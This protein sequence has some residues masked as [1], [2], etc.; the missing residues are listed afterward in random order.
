[1]DSTEKRRPFGERVRRLFHRK[2]L[3]RLILTSMTLFL[4]PC[5]ITMSV[6][7][8][9]SYNEVQRANENSALALTDAFSERFVDRLVLLQNEAYQFAESSRDSQSALF[10][11]QIPSLEQSPY[12]YYT[13]MNALDQYSGTNFGLYYAEDD[14]LI[15]RRGK[16]G[17]YG[18]ARYYL[19]LKSD[20]L[21]NRMRAFM[22]N[23]S[24]KTLSF[25]PL[26]DENTCMVYAA[27]RVRL[28][29]TRESVLLFARLDEL[30]SADMQPSA[31]HYAVLDAETN[32][33]IYTTSPDYFIDFSDF[34]AEKTVQSL[35]RSGTV[36][37][38]FQSAYD[39]LGYRYVGVM[40]QESL[41]SSLKQFYDMARRV[42]LLFCI[43]LLIAMALLI[44]VTYHPIYRL[45]KSLSGSAE[46]S[47]LEV[48]S[49]SFEQI[50]DEKS[51][52][53]MMVIDLLL[54]N[55][56]YG[57][58][59]AESD[60]EN[61]GLSRYSGCFGVMTFSP[62]RLNTIERRTLTA[63]ISARLHITCYITDIPGRDH[64]VMIYLIA[65]E[66]NAALLDYMTAY[67]RRRAP[68]PFELR[69]G[70]VV[71]SI[72]DIHI[73]YADCLST[74]DDAPLKPEQSAKDDGNAKSIEQLRDR[75]LGYL[76]ENF[77]DPNLSQSAVADAFGI[78]VYTLS[79]LF[80]NQV[81]LG[82]S[83]YITGKRLDSAKEMLLT[84]R[85]PVNV[86]AETVGIPSLS[87]FSRLFKL[88]FGVSPAKYRSQAGMLDETG[89]PFS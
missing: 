7:L 86:I 24:G 40:P 38:V 55:L 28:G 19:G 59:I 25:C 43:A 52:L 66:R 27:V 34:D 17:A 44:Y 48:I 53:N 31:M 61:L 56:L 82:F 46:G 62:Q 37:R 14:C 79:R 21:I 20:A 81:G 50:N 10:S 60:L 77:S 73:S 64:T 58:P 3:L 72:N 54:S 76:Q 65:G 42:L 15:T 80:K 49:R 41:T 11:L 51:E 74:P 4:I 57:H 33:L 87:Y 75:I 8:R 88:N 63:E 5:V 39:S 45:A 13:F 18:Y 16:Y 22:A 2:Y 32:A 9:R 69:S 78:S 30:F 68:E 47:E 6:M 29:L 70:R 67:L 89:A 84:T 26:Y 83:E 12:Y 23:K 71:H 1:M 36:Y 85:L 35:T